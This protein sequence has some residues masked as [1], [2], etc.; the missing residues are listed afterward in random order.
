M[1]RTLVLFLAVAICVPTLALAGTTAK[2]ATSPNAAPAPEPM[3]TA[4]DG[5]VTKLD[6]GGRMMTVKMADGTEAT[7]W[8]KASTKF[9]GGDPAVGSM[10]SAKCTKENG[11]HMASSVTVKAKK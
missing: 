4:V 8:Y 10:V 9:E 5:T 6:K 11:K 1:K 7:I 2:A 3:T